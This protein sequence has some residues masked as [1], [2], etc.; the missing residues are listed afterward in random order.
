[1]D[2]QVLSLLWHI[3]K[4]NISRGECHDTHIATLLSWKTRLNPL[5][6]KWYHH[7]QACSERIVLLDFIHRLVSQKNKQNRGIKN[8]DKI[9]QYTRPQNSHKGQ[10]LTTEQ[11]TWMHTHI[12]PWSKSDTGGNKWPKH[13]YCIQTKAHAHPRNTRSQGILQ[14]SFRG[15]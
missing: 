8:M 6:I 15:L 7:L 1:M 14:K 4:L 2:F 13:K 5:F 12:N 10:L 11:L 9:S 3:P